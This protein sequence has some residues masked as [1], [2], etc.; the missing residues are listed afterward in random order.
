MTLCLSTIVFAAGES[1]SE[2]NYPK[3]IVV[4]NIIENDDGSI[5]VERRLLQFLGTGYI[6]GNGVNLRSGPGTSYSSKGYLYYGDSVGV[7][8]DTEVSGDW[9]FVYVNSGTLDG[10]DGYVYDTYITITSPAR[11]SP[12]IE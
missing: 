8:N 6:N 5:T 12:A 3:S 2:K 10:K 9:L 1:K 4:E 7:Y 11:L